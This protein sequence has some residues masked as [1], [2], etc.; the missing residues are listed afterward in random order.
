MLSSLRAFSPAAS[1]RLQIL[2]I[3]VYCLQSRNKTNFIS[4][5]APITRIHPSLFSLFLGNPSI[6]N[7]LLDHPAF[8][9]AFFNKLTVISTGTI[10]PWRIMLLMSSASELP[11]SRSSLNKSPADKWT[12]LCSETSLLHTVPLPDPGPPRTKKQ[13]TA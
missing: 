11:L 5:S 12:N 10:F 3:I 13:V 6:K 2:S 4:V 8:C 7:F 1:P 9:I